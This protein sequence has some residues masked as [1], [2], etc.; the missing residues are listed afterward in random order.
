MGATLIRLGK[1][2]DA[3]PELREELKINPSDVDAQYDLA[4]ALSET[5]HKEEALTLLHS[6]LALNP[7]YSQA[8]YQL[9]K[10]LLEEGKTEEAIGHLETTAQT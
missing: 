5:S 6:V 2:N 7:N 3:I 8:H 1:P 10:M 4:Y 9:G